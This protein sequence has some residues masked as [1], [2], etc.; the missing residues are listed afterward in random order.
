MLYVD[1]CSLFVACCLLIAVSG[2][3]CF[4]GCL[5]LVVYR[6][7]AIVVCVCCPLCVAAVRCLLFCCV[8]VA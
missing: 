2:V 4:V 8:F 5:S 3:V 6:L 7:R 1:R